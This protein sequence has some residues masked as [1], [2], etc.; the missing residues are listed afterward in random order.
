MGCRLWGHKELDTTEGT[1]QQQNAKVGN[2][3]TRGV[4]GKFGLGVQN[5]AGQRLTEFCQVNIR[6]KKSLNSAL[7]MGK[8]CY[9]I[10]SQ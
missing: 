1:W 7:K 10:I 9:L 6:P 4:T 2:Q 5:E 8:F 3:E